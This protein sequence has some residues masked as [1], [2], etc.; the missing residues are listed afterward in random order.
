MCILDLSDV[1][2]AFR[3]ADQEELHP[4]TGSQGLGMGQLLAVLD[5]H[6]LPPRCDEAE[7]KVGSLMELN[8]F[9]CVLSGK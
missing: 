7:A 4:D 9:S 2:L 5:H 3:V 8:F 6:D 1:V